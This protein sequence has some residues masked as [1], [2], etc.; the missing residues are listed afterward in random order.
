MVFV[1]HF[2]A[3]ISRYH[4]VVILKDSRLVQVVKQELQAFSNN[5]QLR[6]HRVNAVYMDDNGFL[7]MGYFNVFRIQVGHSYMFFKFRPNALMLRPCWMFELIHSIHSNTPLWRQQVS[8]SY[9]L[10][11]ETTEYHKCQGSYP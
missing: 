6:Y 3:Y 8:Y 4:R 2:V 7:F 10:C 11:P 1:V 9:R 5:S